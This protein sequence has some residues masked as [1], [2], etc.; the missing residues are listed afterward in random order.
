MIRAV[1]GGSLKIDTTRVIGRGADAIVYAVKDNADVVAKIY[2]RPSP[3][4]EDKLRMMLSC[5]PQNPASD[6]EHVAFA[7]P[8]DILLDGDR[9]VAG[10]VMP[11]VND[12]YPLGSVYDPRGRERTL[13]GFDYRHLLR[14]AHNLS[15]AVATLHQMGYVTGNLSDR[16]VLVQ[17]DARISLV[18]CDAFQ[19]GRH[20]YTNGRADFMAPEQ[21]GA[22]QDSALPGSAQDC[23]ALAL[24]VHLLLMD[25]THPYDGKGEPRELGERIR[26]GLCLY[27][28][29]Q[30]EP[31]TAVPP[32][33]RLPSEL[34]QLF[35]S[36]LI[37]GHDTPSARPTAEAWA[38]RTLASE[39][40]LRQCQ[41]IGRHYYFNHLARCPQCYPQPARNFRQYDRRQRDSGRHASREEPAST[42]PRPRTDRVT[43]AHQ[44]SNVPLALVVCTI[45][46]GGLIYL[47]QASDSRVGRSTERTTQNPA[48]AARVQPRP[49]SHDSSVRAAPLVSG[50]D[51]YQTYM[52]EAPPAGSPTTQIGP[53]SDTPDP[54]V[55][56]GKQSHELVR[57][58]QIYEM[59]L[60]GTPAAQSL[61][62][63]EPR[64]HEKRGSEDK[65]P[66]R[67]ATGSEIYR[68][69]LR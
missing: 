7:W 46:A 54:G 62:G 26:A 53:A 14:A 1:Q 50:S 28:S 10:Y 35:R 6:D 60:D 49:G 39:R 56:N 33:K 48:A 27:G 2:R 18:G 8:R 5:P 15:A 40:N 36:A 58:S 67:F 4:H 25:G 22:A 51:I 45:T 11:A 29:S 30:P 63:Q 16:H 47:S 57:G 64:R 12:G 31:P 41:A 23:F 43:A 55:N 61:Q 9:A 68:R 38:E 21:Q 52:G 44:R 59:Y 37:D 3:E 32:L 69:H 34:R 20:R 17:A 66:E 19:I 42:A 24:L 13:P 65:Q